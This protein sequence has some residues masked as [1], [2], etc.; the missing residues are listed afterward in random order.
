MNHYILLG[1]AIVA[2]VVGTTLMKYSEGFTRLWP[3]VAAIVCTVRLFICSR[4]PWRPFPRG[5]LT[6][7]GPGQGSY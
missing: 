5:L 3:S 6:P 4:R 2:E 1:C 7:F